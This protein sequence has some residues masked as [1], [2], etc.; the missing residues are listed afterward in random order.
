MSHSPIRW[1]AVIAICAFT[2]NAIAQDEPKSNSETDVRKTSVEIR[3]LV[4]SGNLQEAVDAIDAAITTAG[5]NTNDVLSLQMLRLQIG[6]GFLRQQKNDLAIQQYESAAQCFMDHMDSP[7]S[8][9]GLSAATRML[10]SLYARNDQPAEAYDMLDKSIGLLLAQESDGKVTRISSQV[11]SLLGLQS[12]IPKLTDTQTARIKGRL[13]EQLKMLVAF[14]KE[15]SEDADGVTA[16]STTLMN[17]ANA[18]RDDLELMG[19]L[20]Q[21][22]E[23][24]VTDAF[25]ANMK[26]LVLANLYASVMT[27]KIS[28]SYRDDPDAA[29]AM[30]NEAVENL[31]KA[32]ENLDSRLDRA[33]SSIK[34]YEGR[35]ETAKKLLALIGQPAPEFE[36]DGWA[37]NGGDISVESLKGKV[38][39]L[40]FWA[41][42][43]GPCIATFPHLR[44][45]NEEYHDQGLQ[46]VGVTRYYGYQWDEE[47]EKAVRGQDTEVAP[48]D[49]YVAITNFL[50]SH[51][52]EHPSF[53]TPK[54]TEMQKAFGVTGIPHAVLIDRQ[55]NIRMIKVG[56]GPANAKAIHEMIKELI[57]EKAE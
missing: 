45:W 19:K 28:Q 50:K 13:K 2:C 26:S 33:I 24:L 6:S 34:R 25:N 9:S 47:T 54:E 20:N 53:V 1:I 8:Q 30:I 12:R 52:L 16:L 51:D 21:Q 48:E 46:I 42:W 14:N 10:F 17:L 43:C 23:T 38:V 29:Q 11:A 41:I 32:N 5:D 4:T 15:N 3:K 40:D 31:E 36:I 37:N 18:N 57:A 35:I 27:S 22:R 49:E 56:S 44:E 7:I 55:G 39:L